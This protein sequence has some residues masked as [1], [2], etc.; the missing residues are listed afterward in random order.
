MHANIQLFDTSMSGYM[1]RIYLDIF[2]FSQK[3]T[4]TY[5]IFF[6]RNN[7]LFIYPIIM[8]IFTVYIYRVVAK[9]ES[10][11]SIFSS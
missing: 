4:I 6:F 10:N 1:C 5:Y 7:Y 2:L 3:N 11:S 8:Q 9:N